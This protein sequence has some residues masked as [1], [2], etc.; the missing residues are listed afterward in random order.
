MIRHRFAGLFLLAMMVAAPASHS[1]VLGKK[2]VRSVEPIP[3]KSLESG[4][5]VAI[6][7]CYAHGTGA[8]RISIG[9]NGTFGANGVRLNTKPSD[10]IQGIGK[11]MPG[12]Y[13]MAEIPTVVGRVELIYS[14]VRGNCTIFVSAR[15]SEPIAK[16]ALMYF[17]PQNG[18]AAIPVQPGQSASSKIFIK[19]LVVPDALIGMIQAPDAQDRAGGKG[20]MI[21]FTRTR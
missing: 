17:G 11:T 18:W 20:V 14:D 8:K 2:P 15:E 3:T 12:T 7:T 21:M 10:V 16:M 4:S 5:E 13:Q 19:Q 9:R 6:D 1:P